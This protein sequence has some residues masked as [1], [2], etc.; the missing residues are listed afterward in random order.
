M[1]DNRKRS[2]G[3][4]GFNALL[5]IASLVLLWNAYKISGFESISSPGSLPMAVALAMV[6]SSGLIL[7]ENFRTPDRDGTVFF[8]DILPPVV[9][10]MMLF[11]SG[12]AVLLVPLGFLPTSLLFLFVSILYLR[13]GGPVFAFTVSLASLIG[14]YVVFRLIFSV[15][16]PA[17]IVPEGEILAAFGRIFTGAN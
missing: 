3:E 17:G 5:F 7:L 6:V 12:Y 1:S 9:I 11:I 10:V 2:A 4:L 8:K 13:H 15:L 14:V 16:M